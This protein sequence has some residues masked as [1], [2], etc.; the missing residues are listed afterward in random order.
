MNAPRRATVRTRARG[1]TLIELMFTLGLLAVLA[2][3]AVPSFGSVL[4]RQRLKAAAENLAV[5]LAELRFEA[6]QRGV[7]LHMH[8]APGP[9]WCYALASASGCDCHVAQSCLL[10]TVRAQDYPGVK[11][12]EGQDVLFEPMPGAGVG[13]GSAL[14][15]SADGAQ[16]RAGLTRLGRPK[17]CAPNAMVSGYPG[18]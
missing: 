8:F 9:D 6:T 10:K 7:P 15:Q 16:L 2:S 18:C 12:V 3:L 4:A 13:S 5:D 14:L 11:L 1:L 17:V